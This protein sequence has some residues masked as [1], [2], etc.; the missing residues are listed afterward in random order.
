[1]LSIRWRWY[2]IP[3]SFLPH[4][5]KEFLTFHMDIK[6]G[7]WIEK[8]KRNSWEKRKCQIK[9][10]RSNIFHYKTS[11]NDKCVCCHIMRGVINTFLQNINFCRFCL[12]KL[13]KNEL[14]CLKSVQVC[15][16]VTL[17]IVIEINYSWNFFAKSCNFIPSIN[18]PSLFEN[19]L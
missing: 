13:W 16:F 15:I 14:Y 8:I 3:Y 12:P 9:H 7:I 10:V 6:K 18:W 2:K 5:T 17:I 1:M 19:F 11:L 4:I